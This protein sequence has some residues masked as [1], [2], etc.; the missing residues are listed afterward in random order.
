ML[1]DSVSC[2]GCAWCFIRRWWFPLVGAFF[3]AA[4][5]RPA[6]AEET[7]DDILRFWEERRAKIESLHCE[8]YVEEYRPP[9]RGI[10]DGSD[11]S[12]PPAEPALAL[13]GTTRF[14]IDGEKMAYTVEP[15]WLDPERTRLG[16]RLRAVYDGSVT[17][18]IVISEH[19]P[20]L[21]GYIQPQRDE[22]FVT[23]VRNRAF[24]L[25]LDPIVFLDPMILV[26]PQ[27]TDADLVERMSIR[28]RWTDG[29]G[30]RYLEIVV[31]LS[32]LSEKTLYVDLSRSG[33]PIRAERRL[34]GHLM[35]VISKEY[36]RDPEIGWRV[37]RW[38]KSSFSGSGE[39]RRTNYTYHC[40]VARFEVNRPVPEDAFDFVFPEGAHVGAMDEEGEAA[41]F[42]ALADGALRPISSDEFGR[43]DDAAPP[44]V[45]RMG[46]LGIVLVVVG[47]LSGVTFLMVKRRRRKVLGGRSEVNVVPY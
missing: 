35:V 5:A 19:I 17:R 39:R 27:R 30:T 43:I 8:W 33:L 28:R 26:D 7:L 11:D 44:E 45:S 20:R 15:E 6:A 23:Y 22:V 21:L 31:P 37:A 32:E 46:R 9:W 2:R 3:F 13:K 47:A 1:V 10:D 41:F 16:G 29:E 25:S 42:V 4:V 12:E 36:M 18:D 40:E 24:W 38:S 34:A 14:V